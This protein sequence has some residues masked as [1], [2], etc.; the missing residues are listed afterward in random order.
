MYITNSKKKNHIFLIPS[1]LTNKHD[2][3]Q[4]NL[5]IVCKYIYSCV[6]KS[7]NLA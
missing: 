2:N 7:S 3:Y 5:K 6:K 4:Q 1:S